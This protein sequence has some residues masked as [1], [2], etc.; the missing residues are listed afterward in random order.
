MHANLQ[1]FVGQP[2]LRHRTCS[3]YSKHMQLSSR[4]D[5]LLA[6]VNIFHEISKPTMHWCFLILF[7]FSDLR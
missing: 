6:T 3:V 4:I 7:D 1:Y 2:P 5:Y